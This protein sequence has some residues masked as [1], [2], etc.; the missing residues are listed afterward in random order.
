MPSMPQSLTYAVVAAIGIT[1]F[2]AII[3]A[4][5]GPGNLVAALLLLAIAIG[6]YWLIGRSLATIVTARDVAAATA[7]LLILC[8]LG[9][10][11]TGY[12]YQAVLFLLE[13]LRTRSTFPIQPN[14]FPSG[15]GRFHR[16]VTTPARSGR[17]G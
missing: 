5:F 6:I 8:A 12:P 7:V 9:D 15:H 17:A 4:V 2:A 3:R 16:P 13:L 1:V 14:R 10:L 11:L